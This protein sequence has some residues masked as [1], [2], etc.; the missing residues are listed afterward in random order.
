MKTYQK[1]FTAVFRAYL[2]GTMIN[3]P[4]LLLSYRDLLK[5]VYFE[6]PLERLVVRLL[7]EFWDRNKELPNYA[8]WQEFCVHAIVKSDDKDIDTLGGPANALRCVVEAGNRLMREQ[9][10]CVLNN[11]LRERLVAFAKEYESLLTLQ[12]LIELKKNNNLDLGYCVQEFGRISSMG[13]DHADLGEEFW[14]VASNI[15]EERVEF[16]PTGLK[17]LDAALGGGMARGEMLGFV[18][19]PKGFKTGTLLNI[20]KNC[21]MQSYTVAYASGE[22]SNA[23]LKGKL[24]CS[25]TGMMP[26][27]QQRD[28]VLAA[29]LIQAAEAMFRGKIFIKKFRTRQ[30]SASSVETWIRA[31]DTPVD[32]IIIDFLDLMR[33]DRDKSGQDHLERVT[34]A[35]EVRDLAQVFNAALVT[36]NKG[37]KE[38]VEK[39]AFGAEGIGLAFGKGFVFDNLVGIGIT[40]EQ[41]KAGELTMNIIYNRYGPSNLLLGCT[42]DLA[43][44]QLSY[45]PEVT[46]KAKA[47]HL[48]SKK[49]GNKE[50]MPTF[51]TD[52]VS[53]EI[54]SL[55]SRAAPPQEGPTRKKGKKIII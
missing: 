17:G 33:S 37:N 46:E 52:A 36:A 12:R 21:S 29:K 16:I 22:E 53:D 47:A 34:T 19:P 10:K 41:R 25:I 5:P 24:R 14:S 44:T 55:V 7:L 13:Q 15:V 9:K 11:Y 43:H 27:D 26:S 8:S 35:E 45:S 1:E 4:A 54:M 28:P 3:D 39:A 6:D 31:L 2:L 51:M 23:R 40:D 32:V 50:E 18:A 49:G 38:T 30:F 42:V 20:A 48:G